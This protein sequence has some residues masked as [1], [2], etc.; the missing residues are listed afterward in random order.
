MVAQVWP[1]TEGRKP[2]EII[3]LD[4]DWASQKVSFPQFNLRLKDGQSLEDFILEVEEKVN[5]I[6]GESTLNEYKAYKSLVKHK[7]R[8]NH[9]FSELSAETTL[10]SRPPGADKKIPAVVVVVCSAAPP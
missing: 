8:V 6:I 10:R 4:V 9:V 5:G 3:F 7:K 1:L 2:S